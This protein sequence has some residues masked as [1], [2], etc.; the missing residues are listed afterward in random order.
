M[1]NRSRRENIISMKNSP[2]SYFIIK[3]YETNKYKQT[4][5]RDCPSDKEG[6]N[7][8]T[9]KQFLILLLLNINKD[10]WR[11]SKTFVIFF[12]ISMMGRLFY[13]PFMLLSDFDY[14]LPPELIA[15]KPIEPRDHSR[16][17]V[18]KRGSKSISEKK[19]HKILDDLGENDVLVVN[20]TRVL[21]ARLK[22]KL[23]SGLEVEIFLHKQLTPNTWDCLVYPWKRLKVGVKVLF[24]TCKNWTDRVLEWTIV[25]VSEYGRIVRFNQ[26]GNDFL[27][28]ISEI[29]ETPLPPY[30]KEKSENPERYQ[31]VY[32]TTLWSV[33]AP[34]AGL[35]FTPELINK[36]K[37]KG[38]KFETV[39]LHVWIG[40]FKN[41]EV[42]DITHHKMHH[43]YCSISKETAERLNTYK[44][45]GKRIIAVGTTSVRTLESFADTK[46]V[47]WYGQKETNIFIYPWYQWKFVD[48][49]ITNFHLPKSTLLM[50]I[51][52][53]AE[54]DF[55]KNAY[56]KAIE[57]RFRF[58]SFGDAM[59]IQ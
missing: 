59:W 25:E 19:F 30:I 18:L 43:E 48:S 21:N 16:L 51:S 26:E 47:V 54:Y 20:E 9:S 33:A 5:K 7:L 13:C 57:D 32:N 1:Y 35:H 12:K 22:G 17:M 3:D 2:L 39:L 46:G 58:F 27:E 37:I 53:F 14:T 31:T 42:E 8:S 50:L 49:I 45:E 38:V 29:W 34:T 41:V 55:I 23:E 56:E 52:S 4:K 6:K 10:V 36:L 11:N 24:P 15:Q 44:K 40:T 28:T